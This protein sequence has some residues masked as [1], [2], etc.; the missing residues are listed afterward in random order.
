MPFPDA[1][2]NKKRSDAAGCPSSV[3]QFREDWRLFVAEDGREN[4]KTIEEK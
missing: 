2:P 1:F 3:S 4:L